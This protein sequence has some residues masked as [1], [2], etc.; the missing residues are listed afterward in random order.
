MPALG[1]GRA[2]SASPL[3]AEEPTPWRGQWEGDEMNPT[4]LFPHTRDHAACWTTVLRGTPSP[5]A[6]WPCPPLLYICGTWG[7]QSL[8]CLRPHVGSIP[9]TRGTRLAVTCLGEILAL[10]HPPVRPGPTQ[11]TSFCLSFSICK[12][13]PLWDE[14]CLPS[15]PHQM[16]QS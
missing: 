16:L 1:A 11:G 2:G 10:P 5:S 9:H 8:S 12:M 15:P 7:S 3:R 13:G 14:C 4:A 6:R